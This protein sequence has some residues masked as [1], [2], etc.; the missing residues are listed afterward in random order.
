MEKSLTALSQNVVYE[1]SANIIENGF[2]HFEVKKE[3]LGYPWTSSHRKGG[4]LG[5]V[6]SISRSTLRTPNVLSRSSICMPKTF[7]GTHEGCPIPC[8]T[9]SQVQYFHPE[10]LHSILLSYH[11]HYIFHSQIYFFLSFAL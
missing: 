5:S 9:G 11:C 10:Y 8:S 3:V 2:H 6:K 7:Q 1:C 4:R